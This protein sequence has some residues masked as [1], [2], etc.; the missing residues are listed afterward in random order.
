M[1]WHNRFLQQAGWT[2]RLRAYLLE[3]AGLSGAR[4]VLEVGCGTGAVLAG[5]AGSASV[6]GVDLDL[7]RLAEA[8]RHAPRAC[9]VCADG[10]C[11]P[12]PTGVFDITFCHYLLLWVSDPL[13]VLCEMKR[14]TRPG[15][16]VLA[17][18]EPDHGARLDQPPGL[19]TLGRLQTESLRRQGADPALGRR[20]ESLFCQAGLSLI[21]CGTL[22]EDEERVLS[23]A[24]QQLEWE[25]AESDLAGMIPQA[26][27]QRLK[28]L[29][30]AAVRRGRRRVVVP[31][32]FA[33]GVV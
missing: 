1:N 15:G 7:T 23:P 16:S 9:L 3:Q 20:L 11:L 27:I 8:S 32:Y 14:L 6:F 12:Y 31:T 21:E 19:A 18:A 4:R 29:D 10:L 25:V 13:Q 28:R 22:Q 17:L 24:E 30:Q 26:E 33:Y 2:S 5:M